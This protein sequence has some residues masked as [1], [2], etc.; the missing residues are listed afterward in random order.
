M[1]E[2]VAEIT[3]ETNMELLNSFHQVDNIA[4]RIDDDVLTKMAN[5]VI[6]DYDLD[7]KSREDWETMNEEG[8]KLARQLASKKT[9]AGKAVSNVKYPILATA[10]IHFSARTYPNIVNN[11]EVVKCHVVG[12][13]PDGEK[14]TR[15][16]RVSSH[17]SY[18]ILEQMDDWEGDMDQLLTILPIP[19]V[20]F[21]KTYYDPIEKK[22]VSEMILPDEFVVNYHAK[23]LESA[24]CLTHEIERT[25]NQI[26][27]RVRSGIFLDFKYENIIAEGEDKPGESTDDKPH[28][29][30]EQHRFWDLD[31]D[32]YQEPY[33]VT[34]HKE[35]QTVVRITARFDLDKIEVNDAG[36]IQRIVPIHHFTRYL[37]MPAFD[38]SIY[39]MGFG[40]LLS[41]LNEVVNTILNQL[42]DAGR[43][44]NR[45]S[46]FIGSG[47]NLGKG[48]SLV[49]ADDEWK[50]VNAMGGDIKKN[51]VPLPAKEPSVVLF[52]LLGLMI[53]VSK[54]LSSVTDVLRGEQPQGNIPATTTLAMIEQGLKVFSAIFRRIHSSLKSEFKKI[55]RLNTLYLSDEEYN[56]VIDSEDKNEAG[57]VGMFK[58]T[59]EYSDAYLDIIPISSTADV[60]DVQKI[61]K[62]QTLLEMRGGG[63]NDMEIN[64]RYLEALQIPDIEKIL[65]P[66][67]AQ[68]DPEILFQ[69]AEL[70]LKDRE[71]TLEEQK[72]LFDRMLG[73]Q[74][75]LKT[76]A[77]AIKAI[78][79]AE[80]AEV[81]PQL[82]AY[83][84]VTDRIKI[85]IEAY[86]RMTE[87]L[88]NDQQGGVSGVDSKP[89]NAMGARPTQGET[90]GA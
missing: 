49:F 60:S 55:R 17:M 79:Q 25:P 34:V 88:A 82:E 73:L 3:P 11:L 1:A 14:A 35:T 33:I 26:T 32:G 63:L 58:A 51:I 65:T 74:K 64:R 84:D 10:A 9:Y 50:Q 27:E 44:A 39:G 56:R 42:L 53:D 16:V 24:T 77:E 85:E 87:A 80:A 28:T 54:E 12:R 31:D 48:G 5:R 70:E 40:I 76:H 62:G 86:Q 45:S 20:M 69:Q 30:L 78:A 29:F 57:E 23:S 13:D 19:G 41:P 59:D 72:Y 37:F 18:Q 71:V 68:P 66:P 6:A 36:E 43:R 67:P 38:G 75:A 47:V 83:K 8:L 7:K 89:G 61:I 21:K 81:G 15:G 46:G 52:S 22:N 2:V 90:P 4:E